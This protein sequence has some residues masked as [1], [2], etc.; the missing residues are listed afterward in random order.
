[1]TKPM[2]RAEAIHRLQELI[3]ILDEDVPGGWWERNWPEHRESIGHALG[4]LE[5][6]VADLAEGIEPSWSLE[7]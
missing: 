5:H 7:R 6:A 2:T 3:A 1:M 4:Q